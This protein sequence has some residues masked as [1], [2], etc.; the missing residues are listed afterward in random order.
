MSASS[1][2]GSLHPIQI[3]YDHLSKIENVHNL[4][5]NP[6]ND[7]HLASAFN[8]MKKVTLEDLGFGSIKKL[9]SYKQPFAVNI[10]SDP[11]FDVTAF[12]LPKDYKMTLHDHPA[13]TVC[14][15]LMVGRVNL[16]SFSRVDKL[17]KHDP[18]SA[19]EARLDLDCVKSMDDEAWYLSHQQGNFH[20]ICALEDSV[21]LDFL[22]PPY[23]HQERCCTFYRAHKSEDGGEDDDCHYLIEP[24]NAEECSKVVLPISAPYEGVRPRGKRKWSSLWKF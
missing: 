6:L 8:S 7:E 5:T 21:M 19:I 11:N 13:M 14:T 17:L 15:K 4:G 10:V 2:T 3:I 9:S 20:E 12:F 22:L 16:R 18:S 1:S 24:L 23:D